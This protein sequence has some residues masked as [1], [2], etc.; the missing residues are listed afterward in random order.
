MDVQ[1]ATYNPTLEENALWASNMAIYNWEKCPVPS[2][3]HEDDN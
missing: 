3:R 2:Q 1:N